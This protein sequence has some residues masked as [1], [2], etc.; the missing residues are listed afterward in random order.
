MWGD[1][2]LWRGLLAAAVRAVQADAAASGGGAAAEEA[3]AAVIV[4]AQLAALVYVCSPPPP[5]TVSARADHLAGSDPA[6]REQATPKKSA[7]PERTNAIAT[8]HVM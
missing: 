5:P 2:R 3:G 8:R 7:P 6:A 1:M 4:T